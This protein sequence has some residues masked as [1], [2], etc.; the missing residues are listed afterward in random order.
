MDMSAFLG[1]PNAIDWNELLKK[2]L[3]GQEGDPKAARS[4]G[5]LSAGLGILANAHK[6]FSGAIG[7]GG[8]LGVQGYN[9]RASRKTQWRRLDL[10]MRSCKCRAECRNRRR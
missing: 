10:P 3:S 5:L 2:A 8:L 1:D 7:E 4:A 6:G 9:A